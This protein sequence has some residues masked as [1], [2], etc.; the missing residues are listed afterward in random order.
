MLRPED[1][2]LDVALVAAAI[3]SGSSLSPGVDLQGL[4][5]CGLRMPAGWDAASVTLQV[6]Y[7]GQTWRDLYDVNGEV[8]IPVAASRHVALEL[9]RFVG[10]G[11]WVRVRSGT[12]AA[13]VNQSALRTIELVARAL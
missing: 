5:L 4:H 1:R 9:G 3:A 6:S 2:P 11:S 12:A 13:P 10:I 7:D 8:A